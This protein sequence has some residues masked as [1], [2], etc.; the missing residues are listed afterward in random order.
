MTELFFIFSQF[1]II[2][3]LSLLNV[4]ALINKNYY[5]KFFSFSEN[6]TFNL[7]IFLNFILLVS[8]FNVGLVF[9]ISSYLI[10]CAIL[11]LIYLINYKILI[12]INRLNTFYFVILFISSSIIFIQI[13]N[14]LVIGWDAQK[15]WIY[16]TLNFFN[17]NSISNLSNLSNSWYPYLG[18]LSWSFFWKISLLEHEY[19]GRLFYVFI[20]LISLLLITNNL[21][22]SIFNKV[23]FFLL[24][25]ILSYDYTIHSHWS[26]FS[27][28]QEILIFSLLSMAIHFLYKFANSNYKSENL[29][30][31]SI[32]LICNLL[33]WIKHEG[34]IISL[35]LILTLIFFFKFES[36]KKIFISVFFFLILFIRFFI[37]EFYE[38]NS[39]DI[40]HHG[41]EEISIENILDK[42][43]FSRIPIILKY[44]FLNIF[45]NYLMLIGIFILLLFLL[46]K[47]KMK[48]L[49]YIF[50][51]IIFNL[52]SFC[53]IYLIT[54]SLDLSFLLQSGMDRVIYQLCPIT[55]L[56]IFEFINKKNFISKINL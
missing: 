1:F 29:N 3:F 19:S 40:Q 8:F 32:L 49:N 52:S 44:L 38:L 5:L 4:F 39:S 11:F 23:I 14:D 43:S 22:I 26:M 15:F 31:F 13:A 54:T 2:Y 35:S 28:F 36:S 33:V 16:K 47:K 21:K 18:S 41:F 56:I 10:Y 24:I 42:I 12:N 51:L 48:K 25:I 53:F 20:Y 50:F 34:F 37:F 9:I 55:F 46:T 6:L 30:L 27:G 45:T 7:I 17:G